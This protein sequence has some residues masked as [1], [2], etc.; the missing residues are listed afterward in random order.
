MLLLPVLTEAGISAE[1]GVEDESPTSSVE[2]PSPLVDEIEVDAV[3]GSTSMVTNCG[4]GLSI[5]LILDGFYC[6]VDLKI[7]IGILMVLNPLFG[8]ASGGM[9]ADETFIAL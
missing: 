4:Y 6:T 9:K 1:I 3:S 5:L 2:F 7:L 8:K